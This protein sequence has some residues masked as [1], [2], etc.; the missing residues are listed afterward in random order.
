MLNKGADN[1]MKV[2]PNEAIVTA[3]CLWLL[4]KPLWVT[5]SKEKIQLQT[6]MQEDMVRIPTD[7]FVVSDN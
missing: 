1:R 7:N 3:Y 6:D 5:T 4:T 2:K